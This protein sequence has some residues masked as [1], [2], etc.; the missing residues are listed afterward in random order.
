[1]VG[2]LVGAVFGN[3]TIKNTTA[4]AIKS[5]IAPAI[6]IVRLLITNFCTNWIGKGGK[7]LEY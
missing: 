2:V 5:S 7:S 4:K 3:R 6:M 1:M